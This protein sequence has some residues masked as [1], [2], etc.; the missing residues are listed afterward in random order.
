MGMRDEIIRLIEEW[1]GRECVH[2]LEFTH[3]LRIAMLTP[4]EIKAYRLLLDEGDRVSTDVLVAGGF[5]SANAANTMIKL[6]KLGLIEYVGRE[7]GKLSTKFWRLV[8]IPPRFCV[9]DWTEWE[10]A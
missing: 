5:G 10:D 9:Q 3:E 2:P 4:R 7:K 1:E 8:E 6:A